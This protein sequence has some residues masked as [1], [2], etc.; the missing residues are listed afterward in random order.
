MMWGSGRRRQAAARW[1]WERWERHV[2]QE[3]AKSRL[4]VVCTKITR[5]EGRCM[6]R[7]VK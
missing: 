7:K 6:Q 3:L 2:P 5:G 1:R 4:I